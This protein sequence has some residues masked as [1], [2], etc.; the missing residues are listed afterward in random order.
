MSGNTIAKPKKGRHLSPGKQLTIDDALSKAK[1]AVKRRQHTLAAELYSAVLQHQPGHPVAKKALRKLETQLKKR[2]STKVTKTEPDAEPINELIALVRLGH[3]AQLELR[4]KE[5]LR[6]YPQSVLLLNL[7]GIALQRQGRLSQAVKV[8]DK[9][10]ALKPD[11][12]ESHSNRGISLKELGQAE[13]ALASYN[14]A[15]ELQPDFP[16]AYLNRGNVLKSLG[17][18]DEAAASH[19]RAI[20]IREDFAEAHRSLSTLKHYGPD[21]N[22]VELMERLFAAVNTSETSKM[23]LGFALAKAHEDLGHFDESFDYLVV[24]NRLRKQVQQYQIQ[25]DI[26]LFAD[27][28]RLFAEQGPSR[29][30]LLKKTASSQPLFIVGM[31]RSGTSLTEQILASHS[32]VYGAG[33]LDAMTRLA[34]PMLSGLINQADNNKLS[35]LPTAESAR[36]RSD[37]IDTLNE[38][39]AHEKIITDKAPLNFRWIGFILSAFPNAR[40]VHVNRDPVATCWSIFKHY[41]PDPCLFAYDLEDLAKFYRLYIDLMTFWRERYPDNIY[42][43]DYERLTEN[44]EAETRKL[45]AF[46]QLSWED[47][48]LDFHQTKRQVRTISSAQVREQM[49]TGSSNAWKKYEHRLQPM[50]TGLVD[51]DS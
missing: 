10:I 9:A 35:G 33:E 50:I 42:E 11:V 30:N 12:A 38:L 16:E 21:D 23:E 28:K 34:S 7:L 49:Y 5:L 22:Q 13:K 51:R 29:D 8:L 3:M 37:Y 20:A 45:L 43:L 1:K 25:D 40:I 46:C 31:L 17:R 48:C 41:F 19:E 26:N 4:S 6:D 2:S 47:Q 39:G 18:F 15:I 32:Q 27:L 14:R 36:L 24:G 44:Q